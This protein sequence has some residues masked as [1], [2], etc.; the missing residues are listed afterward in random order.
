[1]PKWRNWLSSSV[2]Y[3]EAA[4]ISCPIIC[5]GLRSFPARY[6][7]AKIF[8]CGRS[9]NPNR[10]RGEII[11]RFFDGVEKFTHQIGYWNGVRL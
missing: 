9:R 8:E 11:Q 1:M 10:V 7:S 3:L 4:T 5:S 2:N 6:A